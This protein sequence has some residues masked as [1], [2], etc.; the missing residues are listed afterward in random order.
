M[1]HGFTVRGDI[2]DEQVKRDVEKSIHLCKD[3][4]AKFVWKNIIYFIFIYLKSEKFITIDNIQP[5]AEPSFNHVNL[6]DS[7]EFL[8]QYVWNSH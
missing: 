3:Y 4:F 1:I 5:A 7:D 6:S 2:N 8:A